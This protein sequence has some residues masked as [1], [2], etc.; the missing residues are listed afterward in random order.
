MPLPKRTRLA[1]GVFLTEL[2][3]SRFKR[4]RI[5][6]VLLLPERRDETA[7][8]ALLPYLTERST[9][10]CRTPAA[11]QRRLMRLYGASY[12]CTSDKSV[13]RR[14][15]TF[16]LDG[17]RGRFLP[18]PA[19]DREYLGFLLS[20]MLQPD[21]PGGCFGSEAVAI[22]KQ[23]LG[24]AIAASSNDKR[25]YCT[26]R[27]LAAFY[28]EGDP[29]G[30]DPLGSADEL[31]AIDAARLS[32]H[33]RHFLADAHIELF[34]LNTEIP[35]GFA[36]GLPPR[37][38]VSFP[39]LPAVA[40]CGAVGRV[41]IEDDVTQ[42]VETLLFTAGRRLNERERAAFRLGAALLG[43]I[44]TSRLFT[45]V[46]EKQSLCYYCSCSPDVLNAARGVTTGVSHE[47]AEKAERSVLHELEKLTDSISD[48]ELNE[49]LL[50]MHNAHLEVGEN[51]GRLCGWYLDR[52]IVGLP[53]RTPAEELEL[54][55]SI[56]K[57]EIRDVMRLFTPHTVCRL[58]RRAG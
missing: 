37:T 25:V 57:Q 52:Q 39:E 27:G 6:A 53:A 19:A 14:Y 11:L 36:A 12:S 8:S 45:N 18:D 5:T 16:T 42:E 33:F 56:T 31:P 2:K 55:Q 3:D 34:A 15:I 40:P 44:P 13:G 50:L 1:D 17:P 47:S 22:E 46:R 48:R 10:Q 29:R 30:F 23:K 49:T 20:A 7:M 54:L 4:Q 32:A 24:E 58:G 35:D 26:R 51:A 21:M 43:G 38:E 9:A 28:G 41:A